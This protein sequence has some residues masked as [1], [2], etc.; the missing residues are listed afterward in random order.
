MKIG[1]DACCWGNKRGFGRFTRDLL[2]AVLEIDKENEYLFF[3]D[4]ETDD[5]GTI[6]AQVT[7]IVANTKH[8]SIKAASAE[9]RRL[10]AAHRSGVVGEA[11]EEVDQVE[12]GH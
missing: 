1:V 8:S 3:I 7:K 11:L 9:G 10:S 4:S 6:P 12:L 5:T 2:E